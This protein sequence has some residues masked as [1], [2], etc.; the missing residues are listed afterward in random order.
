MIQMSLYNDI[1]ESNTENVIQAI[2]KNRLKVDDLIDPFKG[3]RAIHDAVL[4]DNLELVNYLIENDAHLMARDYN[5]VT[6]FL[7][8]AS[9]NRLNVV[10]ALV[11]AG[12]PINHKDNKGRN[13]KDM[14]RLYS[15]RSTLEYL[16]SLESTLNSEKEE[17][18]KKKTFKQK[19]NLATWV[20]KQF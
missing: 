4:F 20:L 18:W 5:G 1:V 8:A 14:A 10:K 9:L 12:V 19:Y 17:Y 3:H 11:Q 15:H 6:P 7:K 16:N 13:A 2:E